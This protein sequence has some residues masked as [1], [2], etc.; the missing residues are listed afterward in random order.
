MPAVDI[1]VEIVLKYTVSPLAANP[2]PL[3]NI[4]YGYHR[5]YAYTDVLG[6][7][8]QEPAD[9]AYWN[10]TTPEA[11]ETAKNL[12]YE[13]LLIARGIQACLNAGLPVDMIEVGA[14]NQA[15]NAE[16]WMQDVYDFCKARNIGVL[17]HT[18]RPYPKY[19]QGLLHQG[20]PEINGIWGKPITLNS[21]GQLWSRNM[22]MPT[23]ILAT[24]S[25]AVIGGGIGYASKPE[26]PLARMLVGA[27]AGGTVGLLIDR[28]LRS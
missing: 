15:N 22:P 12:L 9:I 13:E 10:A 1:L 4:R 2:I 3:P 23:P 25:L 20:S 14:G 11:L 8:Y 28:L 24:L 18:F 5:H 19:P 26:K 6:T 17:H 21:M 27:V 16:Q 7:G